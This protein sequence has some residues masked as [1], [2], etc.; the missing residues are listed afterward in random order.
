MG[1]RLYV[2]GPGMKIKRLYLKI[3][4]SFLGVLF[5]TLALILI[6]FIT[7][8]SRS[9]RDSL[10]KKTFPKLQ[11]FQEMVQE[12]IDAYPS[13][14]LG[15]NPDLIKH[16]NTFSTLFNLKIWIS[17]SE[18]GIQLKTFTDPV[19][20]PQKGFHRQIHH[21]NGITL[22]HFVRKWTK[23]YAIIPV[24]QGN[25]ELHLHLYYDTWNQDRP[26]GIFFLGILII[27]GMAALLIVP[28]TRWIT[29]RINRLNQSALEFAR[30]NLSC[31]TN[32]KGHDEIA[33]LGLSF[34]FMADKLEK[35]IR[36]SKDLTT[37]ISHELR[38][39]LTRIRVSKELILDKLDKLDKEKSRADLHRYI[40]NM[41]ADIQSLDTLIDH[42][43]KLSKIDFQESA[44][45]REGFYFKD[46]LAKELKQYHSML[47]QKNIELQLNLID[48]VLISQDKLVLKSVLTNLMDNAVKY[49]AEN[50]KI[51]IKTLAVPE[52]G[53]CF[54]LTNTCSPL[55]D[56]ELGMIFKPF[57]RARGNTAPGTGLGLTIA[58]KQVK[59]CKGQIEARN[60]AAGLTFEVCLP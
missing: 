23:Y 46:F 57:Y 54:T 60:T 34:N 3:L 24:K 39:P 29:Q 42:M 36:G 41:E 48:P 6:L 59:R 4:L 55:D 9:L 47:Q 44:L 58:K 37:N 15:Q 51:A 21:E 35:L 13:L 52:K 8:D 14:S 50:G 2:C 12:K 49:T 33:N 22:Y 26:E 53:L 20:V 17:D 1:N 56:K 40:E 16:L 45:S 38:S 25:S 30:G 19:N 7:I 31:R 27:G 18:K 28:L 32:I 43:L 11:I 5:V 10:D